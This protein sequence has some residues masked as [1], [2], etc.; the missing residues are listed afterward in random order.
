MKVYHTTVRSVDP[1]PVL[2]CTKSASARFELACLEAHQ[3]TYFRRL[4]HVASHKLGV[5]AHYSQRSTRPQGN[6]HS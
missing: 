3:A 1:C 6:T 4:A 2:K 5:A